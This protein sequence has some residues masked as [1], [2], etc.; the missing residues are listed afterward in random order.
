MR[1]ITNI[2]ESEKER[3]KSLHSFK[4]KLIKEQESTTGEEQKVTTQTTERKV[5]CSQTGKRNCYQLLLDLQVKLN[6]K[7]NAGLVEDGL[8]GPKTY[9]AV[10]KHLNID[11][12]KEDPFGILNTQDKEENVDE[13]DFNTE[14]D[15]SVIFNDKPNEIVKVKEQEMENKIKNGDITFDTL[16]FKKGMKTWGKAGE[17]EQFKETFESLPFPMRV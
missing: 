17:Q 6:D 16:V 5:S 4:G 3:I 9:D 13:P 11:L 7:K 14:T 10:L 15:Y 2:S 8:Y 1:N 12:N